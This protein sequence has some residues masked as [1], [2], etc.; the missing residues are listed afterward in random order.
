[1]RHRGE[2]LAR[3]GGNVDVDLGAQREEEV[4]VVFRG[5]HLFSVNGWMSLGGVRGHRG[6]YQVAAPVGHFF[7][8]AAV[9]DLSQLGGQRGRVGNLHLESRRSA[10]LREQGVLTAY[11]LLAQELGL[12]RG[13][14][15]Y[16]FGGHGAN[17]RIW[18]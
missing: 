6:G 7:Q 9:G 17:G 18:W 2:G 13:V 10:M 11:L 12:Y 15:R 8:F 16:V 3:V 1:M 5:G 14:R 4:V